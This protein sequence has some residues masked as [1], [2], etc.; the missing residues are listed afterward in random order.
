[1]AIPDRY[2]RQLQRLIEKAQPKSLEELQELMDSLQGKPLPEI[3]EEELTPE[4]RAY[5]L[6][7]EAWSSSAAKGQKLAMQ[8]LELWP[9]CIS[10]YEYLSTIAK[11]KKQWLACIEKGVEIG[12]RLF[13]GKFLKENAGHFW[14]ITETRPYMRCLKS[15]AQFNA[16]EGNLSKAI[17][18][19]EDMLRLNPSDNQGV[20][21]SLLPALLR[22]R[23]LKSYREYCE[24]H[25]EDTS[26]YNF[27]DALAAFME[28]GANFS[29]NR[30]LKTAAGSN[31]FIIPLLLHDAPTYDMPGSYELGGPEEAQIYAHDAW[32]LWREI[33]G[34]LAWLREFQTGHKP[35]GAALPLAQLPYE[36]L[37]LLLKDPYSPASPLQLSTGLKDEDV[38]HLPFLQLTRALLGSIQ[39]AESLKLT[40]QG[41]LPRA[42][43]HSLYDLR[44]FPSK[45]VDDGTRKLLGEKDFLEL[46]I[47]HALCEIAK[48]TQQRKGKASLTKKGLQL[49]QGPQAE[50]YRELVK[51][52]TQQYNWAYTEAWSFGVS[53]TGQMGWAMI[54]YELIRQGDTPQG[55][56]YYA[57]LYLQFFPELVKQ[58]P[59]SPY[60]SAARNAEL[61]FRRRFFSGFAAL[62]GLV[63]IVGETMGKHGL[64]EEYTVRR[65]ELGGR[66]F[67]VQ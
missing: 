15:L 64:V 60:S 6:V 30:R 41:Y 4:D 67:G 12:Q 36:S 1:M 5:D 22:Q 26:P 59:D 61:D 21:Y 45:Y 25:P 29:A 11:S 43:V 42:L 47:A 62:F 19:W 58:Y 63:K 18:I 13:G 31:P 33:P 28:K 3:P 46:H 37:T 17:V 27:N 8:A 44:L 54:M 7:D 65:S 2:H 51:T 14:G 34:A 10:A 53:M 50:L 32:Q 9:D 56:K 57:D 55:D 48:L 24:K 38:A 39:Q 23:D 40:Q 66:V 49:L 20:R 35:R 52:Y 16:G